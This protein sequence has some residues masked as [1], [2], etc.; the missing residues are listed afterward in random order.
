MT[1]SICHGDPNIYTCIYIQLQSTTVNVQRICST[2]L[3]WKVPYWQKILQKCSLVWRWIDGDRQERPCPC[4]K[5]RDY[6]GKVYCRS[7]QQ[8]LDSPANEQ[9]LSGALPSSCQA[10]PH[11]C[12]IHRCRTQSRNNYQKDTDIACVSNVPFI[13]SRFPCW[14]INTFLNSRRCTIRV[15]CAYNFLIS[16]WFCLSIWCCII[17]HPRRKGA[18][19]NLNLR[20]S[21]GWDQ[22]QPYLTF[23][24]QDL[25]PDFV[26]SI[27]LYVFRHG[28]LSKLIAYEWILAI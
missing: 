19:K 21:P 18:N 9:K 12:A 15:Y 23:T 27:I 25:C 11:R 1:C 17:P 26:W 20:H 10:L 3:C 16:F 8:I 24:S 5:N 4:G 2:F 28:S 6:S 13:L 22:D 14:K 7:N